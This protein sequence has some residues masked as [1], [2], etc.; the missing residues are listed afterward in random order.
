MPASDSWTLQCVYKYWVLSPQNMFR[1]SII[2]SIWS[3]FSSF[4]EN[5]KDKDTQK[6]VFVCD[7]AG[8]GLVL[9]NKKFIPPR[10]GAI[11]VVENA[12]LYF[13]ATTLNFLLYH[14]QKTFP[15]IFNILEV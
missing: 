15:D 12:I 9:W 3:F 7:R 8:H 4:W 10:G 1:F 2:F 5:H 6:N 13:G 11:L 14:M